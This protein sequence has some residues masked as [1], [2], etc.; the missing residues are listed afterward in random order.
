ML[1]EGVISELIVAL[2]LHLS[3]GQYIETASETMKSFVDHCIV[4]E[5]KKALILR[6]RPAWGVKFCIFSFKLSSTTTL[7]FIS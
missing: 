4:M 5:R 7:L 2:I 3:K 6:L 1:R